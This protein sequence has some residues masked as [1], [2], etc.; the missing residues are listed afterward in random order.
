MTGPYDKQSGDLGDCAAKSLLEAY[1]DGTK[2]PQYIDQIL[3]A[4]LGSMYIGQDHETSCMYMVV[5]FQADRC[6]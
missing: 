2:D 1:G 3:R 5:M 6:L 4:T